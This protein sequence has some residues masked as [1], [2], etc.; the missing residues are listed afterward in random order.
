M[1]QPSM[2]AVMGVDQHAAYAPPAA[3]YN[4]AMAAYGQQMAGAPVMAMPPGSA[5]DPLYGVPHALG[6]DEPTPIY[7]RCRRRERSRCR[8]SR[9]GRPASKGGGG[10]GGG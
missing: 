6:A 4:P 10:S 8:H 3:P 1:T 7:R 5:P 9:C 2:T